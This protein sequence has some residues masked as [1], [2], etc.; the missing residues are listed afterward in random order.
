MITLLLLYK[1][2]CTDHIRITFLF[3]NKISL[4]ISF[5]LFLEF[6]S[7]QPV[8]SSISSPPHIPSPVLNCGERGD[9]YS[10]DAISRFTSP[11]DTPCW[12]RSLAYRSPGG[13]LKKQY[14]KVCY[15]LHVYLF[16]STSKCACTVH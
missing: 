13:T 5:F 8:L 2:F 11:R 16:H 1:Y 15:L 7:P 3:F 6:P 14:N 4:G 10:L 9:K 12:M